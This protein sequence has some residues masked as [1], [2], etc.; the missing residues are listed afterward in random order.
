MRKEYT[1]KIAKERICILLNMAKKNYKNDP[2]LAERY[3]QL[4][5][6]IGMKCNV[7][8]P[9]EDR[10]FI[11]KECNT[12]LI[13]GLNCLLRVRSEGGTKTVITCLKCGSRKRYPAIKEKLNINRIKNN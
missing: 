10:F 4:A 7:R 2:K 8:V 6:K 9:K 3:V 13:P 12:P 5:R 1:K 11:C